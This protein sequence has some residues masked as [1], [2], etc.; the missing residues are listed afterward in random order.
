MNILNIICNV[1]VQKNVGRN[2][3]R[4]NND[5]N[6]CPGVKVFVARFIPVNKEASFFIYTKMRVK[7]KKNEWAYPAIPK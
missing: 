2:D 4:L 5:L 6:D 1:K 3:Q 7:K